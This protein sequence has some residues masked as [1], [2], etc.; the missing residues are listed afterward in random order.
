LSPSTLRAGGL[1]TA[2]ASLVVGAA[3][4]APVPALAATHPPAAPHTVAGTV[5][6]PLPWRLPVAHYRLTGRF[7]D[8]S[9]LWSKVHTG[10]DFAAAYG[11]PIRAVAPGGVVS[12]GYDG[13]YG[14]KTVVRLADGTVLW[15]CH[16]SRT[17][18]HAGEQ[19]AAGQV[20]GAIGSTGNTTGPH[21][22]LEVHEHGTPVDPYP[23]LVG[24]GA[25]P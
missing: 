6:R 2:L 5:L 25:R 9:G 22:H 14:D 8:V 23:A 3:W 18:V 21:L 17:R 20:I 13:A 24:H 10:L 15:Y 12:V 7:G 4:I 11:T 19:V 16:Q 1:R